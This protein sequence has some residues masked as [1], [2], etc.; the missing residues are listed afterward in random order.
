MCKNETNDNAQKVIKTIE[1]GQVVIIRNNK[2]Y[3]LSG[4]EL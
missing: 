1:N 3:D 2:K 4:R